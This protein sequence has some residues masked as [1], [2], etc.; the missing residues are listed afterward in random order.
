MKKIINNELIQYKAGFIDG[1][2]D[3][4]EQIV[5]Q[6]SDIFVKKDLDDSWYGYGYN[7]AWNFYLKE[8][9]QKGFIDSK[10]ISTK[11]TNKLMQ[12]SYTDR[13]VEFNKE[14]GENIPIG[15]FII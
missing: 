4:L 14:K 8:Y 12:A 11:Y 1:K 7:D 15:K 2:H 10:L 5:V 3:I 6:E 9:L 13:V